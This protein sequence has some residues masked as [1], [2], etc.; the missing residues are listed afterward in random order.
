MKID[1]VSIPMKKTCANMREVRLT[2]NVKNRENLNFTCLLLSSNGLN[3]SKPLDELAVA[4][5]TDGSC[6]DK[7]HNVKWTFSETV[8]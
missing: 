4:C 5:C 2:S 1:N 6:K 7:K 3:S 8:T